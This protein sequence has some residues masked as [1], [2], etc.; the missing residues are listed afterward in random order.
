MATNAAAKSPVTT[1][2]GPLL[3]GRLWT[4]QA[5][6]SLKLGKFRKIPIMMNTQSDEG[7]YF[8]M[9][10][11]NNG[12]ITPDEFKA[13]LLPFMTTN[14]LYGLDQYYPKGGNPKM[15]HY[16]LSRI[17]TEY[18][19]QCPHRKLA[20][21]YAT[22]G[23]PVIKSYF[24]HELGAS[25]LPFVPYMGVAHGTDI[26][27]WWQFLVILGHEERELARVMLKAMIDFGSCKDFKNCKIGGTKGSVEWPLYLADKGKEG[28]RT[29]LQIPVAQ[30]ETESDAEFD[31][32]CA[33]FDRII[34]SKKGPIAGQAPPVYIASIEIPRFI[35]PMEKLVYLIGKLPF[36]E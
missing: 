23:L 13:R 29:R 4:R 12:L 25:K 15:P 14:E 17:F 1:A 7:N 10:S 27:F 16:D 11:V 22:N 35:E 19:F 3:D 26:P 28:V 21:A 18:Y 8:I 32:R 9:N 33:Y 34:E 6:E 20:L 31:A 30:I 2:Y 24:T 36:D 5:R